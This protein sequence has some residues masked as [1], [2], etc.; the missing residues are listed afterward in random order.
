MATRNPLDRAIVD[1]A[2]S[3]AIDKGGVATAVRSKPDAAGR[4][5]IYAG[6]YR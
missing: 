6:R 3:L 4:Q 5:S 1:T 2:R